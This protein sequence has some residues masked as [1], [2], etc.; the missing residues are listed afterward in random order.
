MGLAVRQEQWQWFSALQI[1]DDCISHLYRIDGFIAIY[2]NIRSMNGL[3]K[4]PGNS[5]INCIGCLGEVKTVSQH[6][7]AGQNRYKTSAP[8]F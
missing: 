6:H 5:L 3:V 1:P 8:D 7:G 2:G 4:C